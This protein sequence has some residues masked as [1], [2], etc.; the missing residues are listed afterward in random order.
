MRGFAITLDALVA[1]SFFMVAILL[2]ASQGYQPVA[3]GGVYM[4]QLSLDVLT[5]LEKSGGMEQAII[6]NTSAVQEMLEATPVS[7]CMGVTIMDAAGDVVITVV[8]SGCTETAGLDMQAATK[9][10]LHQGSMYLARS[11]S[12]FRKEPD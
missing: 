1:I 9:P 5:V 8:K 2:I 7:A 10:V 12:W 4:K 6:G 3:P 11:Q